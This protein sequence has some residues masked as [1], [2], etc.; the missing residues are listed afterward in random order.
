MVRYAPQAKRPV[1]WLR[2]ANVLRMVA[3]VPGNS[4]MPV[5]PFDWTIFESMSRIAPPTY[6][7][8]FARKH[9]GT[10]RDAPG[11]PAHGGTPPTNT[12]GPPLS[13]MMLCARVSMPG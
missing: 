9:G 10:D 1:M 11:R 2:Q 4:T 12:P 7:A 3:T 8:G 6:A 5:L 13:E